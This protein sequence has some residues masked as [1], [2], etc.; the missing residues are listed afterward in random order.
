MIIDQ[1]IV[2]LASDDQFIHPHFALRINLAQH[3]D[4]AVWKKRRRNQDPLWGSNSCVGSR[5]QS[6]GTNIMRLPRRRALPVTLEQ[7]QRIQ[8]Q[9][10][11]KPKHHQLHI[12][13]QPQHL[14]ARSARLL[15]DSLQLSDVHVPWAPR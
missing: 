4:M 10:L 2:R 5:T 11:V 7:V 15:F 12:R 14:R 8:H 3:L 1:L 9:H 6:N 13:N